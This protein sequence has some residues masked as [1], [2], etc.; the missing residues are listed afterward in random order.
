MIQNLKLCLKIL[1]LRTVQY[2]VGKNFT[3][4]YKYLI[5]QPYNFNDLKFKD[6]ANSYSI[7]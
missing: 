3:L 5:L 2:M 4:I 6:L 1:L 7:L